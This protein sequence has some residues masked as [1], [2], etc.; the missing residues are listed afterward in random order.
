M[1][2]EN[3]SC[4]NQKIENVKKV[5]KSRIG[6]TYDTNETEVRA[7]LGILLFLGVEKIAKENATSI[8]AKDSTGMSICIAAMG[9]K[10]FLFLAYCLRFD[11]STTRDQAQL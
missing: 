5:Y 4:T 3:V 11:D 1:I 10:L 7:L 8:W 2:T 6:F 9:K